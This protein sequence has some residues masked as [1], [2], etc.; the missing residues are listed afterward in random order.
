MRGMLNTKLRPRSKSGNRSRRG[1]GAGRRQR[2][3]KESVQLLGARG[4]DIQQSHAGEG[5]GYGAAAYAVLQEHRGTV[6]DLRLVYGRV[7]GAGAELWCGPIKVF[8]MPTSSAPA[9]GRAK[10]QRMHHA[11]IVLGWVACHSHVSC[12]V[13]LHG[14]AAL[15]ARRVA[16][17]F[18]STTLRMV[19]LR[20]PCA[21]PRNMTPTA[22]TGL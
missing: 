5:G 19:N 21:L 9:G 7:L 17:R 4:A 13:S 3:R 18:R 10:P 8:G 20:S 12:H 2:E 1:T 15:R 11:I 6:G 22:L 14:S 16:P